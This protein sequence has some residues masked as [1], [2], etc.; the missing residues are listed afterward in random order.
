MM[1]RIPLISARWKRDQCRGQ[2]WRQAGRGLDVGE[3]RSHAGDG[4]PE[5]E[6]EDGDGDAGGDGAEDR[7][8]GDVGGGHDTSPGSVASVSADCVRGGCGMGLSQSRR[9]SPIGA[10][11]RRWAAWAS[12]ATGVTCRNVGHVRHFVQD[13]LH[14]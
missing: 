9:Q 14:C 6:R 10:W 1:A 7:G 4:G 12:G 8:A 13:I 11:M 3:Q 5:V 2:G